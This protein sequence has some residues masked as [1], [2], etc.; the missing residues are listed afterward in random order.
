MDEATKKLGYSRGF[1]EGLTVKFP[2]KV[3]HQNDDCPVQR[4][5]ESQKASIRPRELQQVGLEEGNRSVT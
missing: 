2:C 5:G 4:E 3:R 1:T